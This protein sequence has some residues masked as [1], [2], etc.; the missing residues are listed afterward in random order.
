MSVVVLGVGNL[1]MSDEGVGVHCVQ[2][3]AAQGGIP[4]GVRLVDG[5]TST[6]EL[7]EDLENLE[8]LIIV[9]AVRAGA[10]PGTVLRLEGRAVPSAFTTKLSPHQLGIADLL[11][12]LTFL[13]RAP[14]H[15]LLLGVEPELLALGL[16]LSP[17]VAARLPALCQQVRAELEAAPGPGPA[18]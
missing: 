3:L 13:G 14:R 9:D 6:Q 16:E 12:T 10:A 18:P 1:L 7:L 2:A 15:V 8:R 4:D 17:T 5:G 11:A